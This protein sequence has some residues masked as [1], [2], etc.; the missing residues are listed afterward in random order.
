MTEEVFWSRVDKQPGGCWIYTGPLRCGYGYV[1]R[2]GNAHVVAWKLLIGPIPD[3]M[4]LDHVAARGC[5]SRACCNPAHLEPVT[6]R[7][8]LLRSDSTLAGINAR[9]THCPQGHPFSEENTEHTPQGR[10]KCRTCRAE[11]SK[12]SYAARKARAA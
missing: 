7:E 1:G 3:G 11:E 6:C 2:W 8:N 10:R 9:K 4:Q 5:V 12:R